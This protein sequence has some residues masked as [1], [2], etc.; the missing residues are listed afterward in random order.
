MNE[1]FTLLNQPFVA[2][3]LTPFLV[4]KILAKDKKEMAEHASTLQEGVDANKNQLEKATIL[5]NRYSENQFKLYN[6]LYASLY[7]LKIASDSLWE[8]ATNDNL[9]EFSKQFLS[10]RNSIGKHALLI[11]DHHYKKLNE[12]T[13]ALSKIQVGKRE[14]IAIRQLEPTA[15]IT[16]NDIERITSNNKMHKEKYEELLSEI[17][18]T[19]RR[20][21]MIQEESE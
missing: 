8:R 6:E 19:F 5:F 18:E 11:E 13:D 7:D 1:I 12:I 9:R 4:Y 21:L 16:K 2:A 3:V 20:N 10:A 17:R 14:L 15:G